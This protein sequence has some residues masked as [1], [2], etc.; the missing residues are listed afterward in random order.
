MA[1]GWPARFR[2]RAHRAG[3][4][5]DPGGALVAGTAKARNLSIA[6]RDVRGFTGLDIAV[7][8]PRET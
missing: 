5:L 7:T 1:A 6:A 3:R 4:V 2:A 8:N